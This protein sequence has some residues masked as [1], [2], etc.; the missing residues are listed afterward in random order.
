[1]LSKQQ[2]YI[3]YIYI[4]CRV[5]GPAFISVSIPSLRNWSANA[6]S[7]STVFLDNIIYILILND[8]KVFYGIHSGDTMDKKLSCTRL[9][10]VSRQ[11]C[12]I[13]EPFRETHFVHII[14]NLS[15]AAVRLSE[16]NISMRRYCTQQLSNYSMVD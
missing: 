16:S 6:M 7:L 8:E 11:N 13:H 4:Y 1:M 5:F 10:M 12:D 2:I 14:L 15:R 9:F 3:L